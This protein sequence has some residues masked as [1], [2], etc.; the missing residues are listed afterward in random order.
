VLRWLRSLFTPSRTDR[1]VARFKR[2][3]KRAKSQSEIDEA[4]G[5]LAYWTKVQARG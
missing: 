1:F 3:L 4:R 5:R 2:E